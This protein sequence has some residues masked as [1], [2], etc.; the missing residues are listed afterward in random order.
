MKKGLLLWAV[1]ILFIGLTGCGA[2][3]LEG[4]CKCVVALENVPKE[5]DMLDENLLE[6]FYVKVHMENI[7][8][9]KTMT[10]ELNAE[11]DFEAELKLQPGTY[12][13]D[14]CY[15]GP[16]FLVPIEVESKVEKVELTK[17]NT[18]SVQVAITNE[19]D[20]VDWAWSMNPS[21]EILE[22]GA[23]S[24]KVQ[25]EGQ[26]I[27]LTEITNYVEF[28]YDKQ[29]SSYKKATI[30][31]EKG[32]A[33]TVLN[34]NDAAANWQDCKLIEVSFG[35]NNVIW[36]QGA[37][38]GMDV[39]K[40]ANA[41]TGLYG[42]PASMSGTVLVGLGYADTCV[43]WLDEK[44]GDKLTLTIEPGGDYISGITYALEAFE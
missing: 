36:G 6:Q 29:V 17:E 24:H 21:R 39:A 28:N 11:N 26:L 19:S 35:K 41:K 1:L 4:D 23:F 37:F 14:Y 9:E 3:A 25:F 10:V 22:A 15:A 44:S 13:I 12:K 42:K 2:K 40:A 31:G 33:I 34:E 38:I 20:F 16:T 27:D 5:L 18:E 32:V 7:Y 43:S 8:S 30:S